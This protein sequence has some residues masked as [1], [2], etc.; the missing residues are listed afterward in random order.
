MKA[1][2]FV[3]GLI[4]ALGGLSRAWSAPSVSFKVGWFPPGGYYQP[5][6]LIN[7][8]EVGS[9]I[10]AFVDI[11]F[12]STENY[13]ITPKDIV[14][15]EG[16]GCPGQTTTFSASILMCSVLPNYPSSGQTTKRYHLPQ[17]FPTQNHHSGAWTVSTSA[18]WD[19]QRVMP[20][21]PPIVNGHLTLAPI[22]ITTRNLLLTDVKNGVTGQPEGYCLFDPDDP[23]LNTIQVQYTIDDKNWGVGDPRNQTQITVYIYKSDQTLVKTI[24]ETRPGPGAYITPPWD[25]RNGQGQLIP[26]GVYLFKVYGLQPTGAHHNG[27]DTDQ[28]KSVLLTISESKSQVTAYN[29]ANGASTIRANYRLFDAGN[30]RQNASQANVRTFDPS[31]EQVAGPTSGGGVTNP[32]GAPNP[33]W[34]EVIFLMAITIPGEYTHL[35]SALDNHPTEDKAHRPHLPALQRGHRVLHPLADN[36]DLFGQTNRADLK[37]R[38]RQKCLADGTAYAAWARGGQ[39][40]E[41]IMDDLPQDRLFHFAGHGDPKKDE[42]QHHLGGGILTTT[43]PILAQRAEPE[44]EGYFIEDLDLSYVRLAVYEGCNTAV[45]HPDYG[46]IMLRTVSQGAQCAVGFTTDIRYFPDTNYPDQPS[47]YITW[48]DAFW[49]ALAQGKTDLI[50][51]NPNGNPTTVAEALSWAAERVKSNYGGNYF[52]FNNFSRAGND[53]LKIVPA[54]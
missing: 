17:L 51:G 45:T 31:P 25:G 23:A 27:P 33:V 8:G 5:I 43:D 53:A 13:T 18:D 11:T 48:A 28:D 10:D 24:T 20:P 7:A 9:S 26:K 34:N 52:G 46:N 36:Y 54:G 32:P 44:E 47:P 35:V 40:A 12:P 37:A 19:Y 42:G 29:E 3:L 22:S 1:N 6:Q 14:F 39:G 15:T 41:A 49:Q 50:T 38:T 30:P 16:S 2:R 4:L 21:P